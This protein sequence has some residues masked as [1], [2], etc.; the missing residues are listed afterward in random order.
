MANNNIYG[1]RYL[2]LAL[3][4]V[5]ASVLFGATNDKIMH[6]L[7]RRHKGETQPE[8][9]LPATIVAMPIVAAGTLWY[10]WALE[11]KT[12][13]IIPIIGSGVAGLGITTVQVGRPLKI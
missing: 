11:L 6:T 2:G 3:G 13:W 12:P 5:L 10:G 4:F 1:Y 7:A 8:F 9:R